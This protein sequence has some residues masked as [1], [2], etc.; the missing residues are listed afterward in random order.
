MGR[1]LAPG[2]RGATRAPGRGRVAR[3]PVNPAPAPRAAPH[4][5]VRSQPPST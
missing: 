1:T 3:P 4:S 2:P 5:T